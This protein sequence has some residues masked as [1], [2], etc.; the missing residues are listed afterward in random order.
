M[1]LTTFKW[2][3]FGQMGLHRCTIR[4]FGGPGIVAL[5]LSCQAL[6]APLNQ[7]HSVIQFFQL[8]PSTKVCPSL[9]YLPRPPLSSTCHQLEAQLRG[10][11]NLWEMDNPLQHIVNN[12]GQVENAEGSNIATTFQSQCQYGWRG[13][14]GSEVCEY[15]FIPE[16]NMVFMN[17]LAS[18]KAVPESPIQSCLS[19]ARKISI[20][21]VA[22]HEY[23]ADITQI[24]TQLYH[25]HKMLHLLWAMSHA[26][27][28]QRI[29]VPT[30]SPKMILNVFRI[31]TLMLHSTRKVNS[32][33]SQNLAGLQ[34][35]YWAP[36]LQLAPGQNQDRGQLTPKLIPHLRRNV[37]MSR[38]Q[39]L[40]ALQI[41]HWAHCLQPAPGPNQNQRM[42]KPAF[43]IMVIWPINQPLNMECIPLWP[44]LRVGTST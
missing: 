41:N 18:K 8:K 15:P 20:K 30:H 5:T 27:R 17:E 2:K 1:W 22:C 11:E 4:P 32:G 43:S 33:I 42:T 16:F 37:K 3:Y 13:L 19:F 39:N 34:I 21:Q 23:K 7:S 6:P 38:G 36:R 9:Y 26:A 44:M 28:M 40:A 35:N 14:E 31:Q 25:C 29:P 24:A 10:A 12:R